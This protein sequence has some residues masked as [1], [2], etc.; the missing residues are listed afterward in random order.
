MKRETVESHWTQLKGMFTERLRDPWNEM[1]D[2]DLDL[3]T[4]L[5][6]LATTQRESFDLT[7]LLHR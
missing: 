3:A 6:G 7:G 2:D 4:L 1:I 5:A